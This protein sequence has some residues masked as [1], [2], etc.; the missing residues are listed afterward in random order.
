M[1]KILHP[2]YTKLILQ[3]KTLCEGCLYILSNGNC[4]HPGKL[5]CYRDKNIIF[6]L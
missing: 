1:A 6:I 3:T 2:K 4:T 5:T